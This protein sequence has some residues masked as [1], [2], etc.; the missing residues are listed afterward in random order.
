MSISITTAQFGQLVDC[1]S[2]TIMDGDMTNY[3]E[4]IK[5]DWRINPFLYMGTELELEELRRREQRAYEKACARRDAEYVT[6]L[7]GCCLIKREVYEAR[8]KREAT[9]KAEP[10]RQSVD[11]T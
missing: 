1:S 3:K 6:I 11:D 7:D 9:K 4:L 10:H 2:S 5:S 8:E